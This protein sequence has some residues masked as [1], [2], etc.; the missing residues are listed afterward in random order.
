MDITDDDLSPEPAWSGHFVVYVLGYR[1]DGW[2]TISHDEASQSENTQWTWGEGWAIGNNTRG[3][4][5][6]RLAHKKIKRFK[7]YLE[8]RLNCQ[9]QKAKFPKQAFLIHY[10]ISTTYIRVNTLEEAIAL[11]CEHIAKALEMSLKLDESLPEFDFFSKIFGRSKA[12]VLS[13]FLADVRK[14]GIDAALNDSKRSKSTSYR[15]R[16]DLIKLGLID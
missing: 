16:A 15:H 11:E 6:S 2:N 12:M 7:S 8:A 10:C 5:C 3:R 14:N 4:Y 13:M 1:T 9:T